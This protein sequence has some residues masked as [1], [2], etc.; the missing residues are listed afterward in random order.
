MPEE[1]ING[2]TEFKSRTNDVDDSLYSGKVIAEDLAT[3]SEPM[4]W[5]MINGWENVAIARGN[6]EAEVRNQTIDSTV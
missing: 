4:T 1:D 3:R 2:I 6:E 5:S